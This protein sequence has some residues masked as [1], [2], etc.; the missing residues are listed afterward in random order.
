MATR[1]T[2]PTTLQ[3]IDNF[4][5]LDFQ[6]MATPILAREAEYKETQQGITDYYSEL[7]KKNFIDQ[8]NLILEE[9]KNKLFEAEQALRDE[10]NGDL[11]DPNYQRKLD[12][13]FQKESNALFYK[14]AAKTYENYQLWQKFNADFMI[15]NGYAPEEWQD[16][17]RDALS[18]YKGGEVESLT[19]TGIEGRLPTKEKAVE[20]LNNRINIL[21]EEEE[22]FV[23]K[24]NGVPI[25]L[26]KGGIQWGKAE[27]KKLADEFLQGSPY[28]AQE[29]KAFYNNPTLM[30]SYGN[31]FDKYYNESLLESIGGLL[32]I[33]FETEH[34]KGQGPS[35]KTYRDVDA[36]IKKKREAEAKAK[37]DEEVIYNDPTI[38]EGV[39]IGD[40][41]FGY[42][43]RQVAYKGIERYD[44][45]AEVAINGAFDENGNRLS[46]SMSQQV[47]RELGLPDLEDGGDP[48]RVKQSKIEGY[49]AVVDLEIDLP[50]GPDGKRETISLSSKDLAR[51][52][53]ELPERVK[54][55]LGTA[56]VGIQNR[57][58]DYQVSKNEADK[59]RELDLQFQKEA[60]GDEWQKYNHEGLSG[61]ATKKA[62]GKT[63]E[64]VRV[65]NE[66]I[67][68]G[69]FQTP[70]GIMTADVGSD[71]YYSQL[72]NTLI[73]NLTPEQVQDIIGGEGYLK[74]D[75]V[76]GSAILGP[77]A[78]AGMAL[79]DKLG[80]YEKDRVRNQLKDVSESGELSAP[81][82]L[83]KF[84]K[85]KL[86]NEAAAS[87]GSKYHRYLKKFTDE[88]TRGRDKSGNLNPV[89]GDPRL[90]GIKS[91]ASTIV[92]FNGGKKTEDDHYFK[93]LV[94]AIS[95]S[96]NAENILLFDA[97]TNTTATD[98]DYADLKPVF[99]S[100]DGDL[101]AE[102]FRIYGLNVDNFGVN[103]LITSNKSGKIYEWRDQD[104]IEKHLANEGLFDYK[105]MS[106]MK[107]LAKSFE[108]TDKELYPTKLDEGQ[109][110]SKYFGV[111]GDSEFSVPV[112]KLAIGE[113]GKDENGKEKYFPAGTYKYQSIR[114]N[115]GTTYANN[116]MGIALAYYTDK[117]YVI[118]TTKNLDD[119]SDDDFAY[120]SGVSKFK[121]E[122]RKK[123]SPELKQGFQNYD[124]FAG[125]LEFTS[126]YRPAWNPLYGNHKSKH[127]AGMAADIRLRNKSDN[128][129]KELVRDM[130]D[131]S[132]WMAQNN[133]RMYIEA[134]AGDK[135]YLRLL[136]LVEDIE[137]AETLFR[138]EGDG[139]HAHF[140]YITEL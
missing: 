53:A 40:A 88:F 107:G 89:E 27:I 32:E 126:A 139:L 85:Y 16:P 82:L 97:K 4:F 67:Y 120:I 9:R 13:L 39:Q 15:K 30:A 57:M 23:E 83:E 44:A 138:N 122:G 65:L 79:A 110:R 102:G 33:D 51:V 8:D 35:D 47:Q 131:P 100:K 123:M 86:A 42:V 93:G 124:G 28:L 127:G 37:G 114:P 54:D 94:S 74:A 6:Q 75:D 31:D 34:F 2:K 71:L 111:V 109:A 60:F 78:L 17:F 26:S 96:L 95:Q 103:I 21:K 91:R 69:R 113:W 46:E 132:G 90:T 48:V 63:A 119:I 136:K 24:R 130:L 45:E 25:I 56:W 76:K 22:I 29:K 98:D 10:A 134:P 36:K 92:S 133:M 81:K 5:K 105:L 59:I 140:E 49:G 70:G 18:N 1:Y 41:A 125:P 116:H 64:A 66:E 112:E 50:P 118:D 106:T 58:I 84:E 38:I 52:Y 99:D 73:A 104:S 55:R 108:D 11:S 77:Y 68:S 3:P 80:M 137:G 7:A 19:F 20:W 129:I 62:K 14:N 128:D 61:V 87:P 72:S 135:E 12:T 101:K 43:T 117:A 115:G 121:S